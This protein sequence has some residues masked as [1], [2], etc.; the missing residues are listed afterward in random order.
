MRPSSVYVALVLVQV[1]FATL[2]IA[3]KVA[4]R[5]LS[6]PALALLRVSGA[7]VLFLAIHFATGGQRVRSRADYL[8]LALYSVFGVILNQLLY[9]TALTMTT[10]TAAQTLVTAGPALTLLVAILLRHESATPA[11]WLGIALAGCGALLLVGVGLHQGSVLGNLLALTNVTAYSV[12]L[13]ISRDILGRYNALTVIT[14]VFVFGVVGIFPWGIAPALREVGGMGAATWAA[15]AWIVA[16]PTVGAYYLNVWALARA[17]ASLVAM[18]VY[19]QPIM[20]AALAIPFLG[21]RPSPRMIPATLLIFAGVWV[22]IRAGRAAK[23]R[24]GRVSAAGQEG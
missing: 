11:K 16:V 3:V 14:W 10:A 18:F 2:P 24:D 22:S 9:I 23:A 20:T 15:L 1:F 5:D 12:Y 13:V 4:L 17:E 7:A 21:E 8:R 6:S 19:I